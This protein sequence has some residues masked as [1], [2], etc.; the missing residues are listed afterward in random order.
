MAKFAYNNTMH[1]LTQQT[2]FFTHYCLHPKF[3]IQ[4]VN[5]VVNPIVEHQAMWLVDVQVQLV[6]NLEQA[7]RQY[8]KNVN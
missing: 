1:S 6:S 3:D 5:K 4:D 7:Q 8:K 2:T